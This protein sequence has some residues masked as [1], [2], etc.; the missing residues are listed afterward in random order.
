MAKS[1]DGV[2]IKKAHTKQ[3]YTLEEVKHLEGCMDPV[4][5]PLYFAKN[6]IYIQHPTKGSMPFVPYG[7]QEQLLR[8]YH[9]HRYTI[10]MLPR[11]TSLGYLTHL[12][13]I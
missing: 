7:Y 8:A 5:G 13:S 3:K 2:Q 12:I 4:E 6:F 1:L 11:Q 10:A 9:D